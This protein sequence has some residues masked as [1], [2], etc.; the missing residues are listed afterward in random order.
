MTTAVSLTLAAVLLATPPHPPNDVVDLVIDGLQAPLR[1]RLC[2]EI[3]G[4][5]ALAVWQTFLDNLFAACDRNGD[6]SLDSQEISLI[7]AL[8]RPAVRVPDF[9]RLDR[10]R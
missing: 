7:R 10:N 1:I 6:G 9:S 3:D 8:G 4:R 5:P 2:V